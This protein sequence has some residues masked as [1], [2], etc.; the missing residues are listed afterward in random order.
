[1]KYCR[2]RLDAF[3]TLIYLSSYVA[4][5]STNIPKTTSFSLFQLK[6][7]VLLSNTLDLPQTSQFIKAAVSE[8][9]QISI[10]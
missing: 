7:A 4:C 10:G 1:M 5:T 6:V 3:K 8:H 2:K 9:S